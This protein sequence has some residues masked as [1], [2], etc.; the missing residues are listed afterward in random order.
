MDLGVP[1]QHVMAG[2]G[3][4]GNFRNPTGSEEMYQSSTDH[5]NII[6]GAARGLDKIRT[7]ILLSLHGRNGWR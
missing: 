1:N 2:K 7:H 3:D 4:D 6:Q 5:R